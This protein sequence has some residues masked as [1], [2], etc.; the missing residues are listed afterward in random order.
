[1]S[2][3]IEKNVA[4]ILVLMV[5]LAVLMSSCATT[6][7]QCAAYASAHGQEND[8]EREAQRDKELKVMGN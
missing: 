4:E 7:S 8:Y 2:K 5:F 1:M 6:H 3:T